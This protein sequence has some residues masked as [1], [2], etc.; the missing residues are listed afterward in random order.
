M[1]RYL[2]CLIALSGVFVG[3]LLSDLIFAEEIQGDDCV[4]ALALGLVVATMYWKL[5]SLSRGN[6]K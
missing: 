1:N 2:E 3:A 6:P 5:R 4:A